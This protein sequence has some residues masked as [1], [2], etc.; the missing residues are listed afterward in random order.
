MVFDVFNQYHVIIGGLTIMARFSAMR[1]DP[2]ESPMFLTLLI[3]TDFVD[4]CVRAVPEPIIM[5]PI[6]Q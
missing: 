2:K 4:G 1:R 3:A 5:I 6:K